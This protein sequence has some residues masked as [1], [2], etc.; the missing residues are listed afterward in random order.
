[1]SGYTGNPDNWLEEL[2]GLVGSIED[3]RPRC[4]HGECP[5]CAAELDTKYATLFDEDGFAKEAI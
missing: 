4:E 3:N 1:M 2:K 5:E